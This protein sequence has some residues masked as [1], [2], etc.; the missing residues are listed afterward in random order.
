MTRLVI[1]PIAIQ[2]R[3]RRRIDRPGVTADIVADVNVA[4]SHGG[5]SATSRQSAPMR[6]SRRT[7]A[8]PTER[9]PKE[10]S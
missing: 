1:D 7:D 8:A 10:H 3:I 4:V 6:Q 9:D 5:G 2:R